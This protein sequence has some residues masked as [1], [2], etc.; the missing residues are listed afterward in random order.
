[1]S[2]A[3]GT[4]VSAMRT[5]EQIK[6][7]LL[8]VGA[9]ELQTAERAGMAAIQFD[10]AERRIRFVLPLPPLENYAYVTVRGRRRART[11]HQAL[12]AWEQGCRERWR[13][14]LACIKAKLVSAQS[15]IETVEEAFLA[16]V[17]TSTGRTVWENYRSE[18]DRLIP[19]KGSAFILPA[20]GA[21]SDA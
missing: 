17:V 6:R 10:L 1:M 20:L 7:I 4:K 12:Q 16:N 19:P 5:L 18:P 21:G 14:L 9:K 8:E 11:S 3:E 13:A 15:G 2:Y